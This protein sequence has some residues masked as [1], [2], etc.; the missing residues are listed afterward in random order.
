MELSA[1]LID[2]S[3]SR[4][5][6]MNLPVLPIMGVSLADTRWA[7]PYVFRDITIYPLTTASEVSNDFSRLVSYVNQSTHPNR[8]CR[9]IDGFFK[10]IDKHIARCG[11]LLFCDLLM[12]VDCLACLYYASDVMTEEQIVGMYASWV[13]LVVDG[14][15][16]SHVLCSTKWGVTSYEGSFNQEDLNSCF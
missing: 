11:R 9:Y 7:R 8:T 13:K 4:N 3:V 16:K 12:Y 10:L 6:S 1:T 2:G 15:R 14:C 5:I